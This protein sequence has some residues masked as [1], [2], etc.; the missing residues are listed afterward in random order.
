MS[1][2]FGRVPVQLVEIDQDHCANTYGVSPCTAGRIVDSTAASPVETAQAGSASTITLHAST[3]AVDDAYNGMT[4]RITGGTGSGQERKVAD[5]VGATR[6]VTVSVNW[7]TPP[8]STSTYMVLDRPNACVNTFAACQDTD[9]FTQG[10]PKTIRL[11]KPLQDMPA[12]WLAIPSVTGVTQN[13]TRINAGGQSGSSSALGQRGTVSVSILDHPG[14]DLRL[15]PYVEDRAYDPLDRGTFWTKWRARNPYYQNRPIRILNG[16]L[17]EA[18]GD[19][20]TYNY[21][22]DKFSGPDSAGVVKITGMDLLRLVDDNKA[23]AP[24]LSRGELQG[25]LTISATAFNIVEAD[26]S[27]YDAP[28]GT[29][30]IGDEVITYTSMVDVAGVLQVTGATRGT[31]GTAAEAH[32]EEDQVQRCLRYTDEPV[33]D[34]LEDLLTTF[35]GI[36]LANIDSVGWAA[37]GDIW[38]TG[39]ELSTLITE[40]IGVG[41]LVKEICEQ[42]LLFLWWDEREQLIKLQVLRPPTET[43][44][45]L[46]ETAHVLQNSQNFVD[47][48]TQRVSQ[49]YIFYVQRD[50]T[51]ELD[52]ENNYRFARLRLDAT[53][54]G[55]NQYGE[56]KVKK[57]FSRWLQSFGQVNDTGARMLARYRDNP[58]VGT[59]TVDAKDRATWTGDLVRLTSAK[60]VDVNGSQVARQFH[61]ISAKETIPGEQIQYELQNFDP[62]ATFQC[63]YMADD[64]PDY[65]DATDEELALGGWY[66]D[67]DGL[68]SD[69][70]PGWRYQ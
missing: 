7:T 9:N 13:P 22:I 69:G 16:Y 20:Q 27:E 52:D 2:E 5:Y 61:V 51:K 68:M 12:D 35:A 1:E 66:S 70:E 64:A 37:E 36:D 48:P 21:V 57:I 10:T 29:L 44:V 55:V 60:F 11:C 8:D 42:V 43:P 25:D 34:I 28:A 53:A 58:I 26:I 30:R 63:R 46:N 56:V 18:L 19:M 38:L 49:L 6:V 39:Y 14:S 4:V 45:S 33:I 15:D 65:L 50:P 59:V 23:Q 17:G 67:E 40:P 32:D 41:T 31:D 62:V 47:D 3:S 54:Q 24:A